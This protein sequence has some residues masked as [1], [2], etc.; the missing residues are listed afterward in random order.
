MKNAGIS[1]KRLFAG[2]G[3]AMF[4]LLHVAEAGTL[5][6]ATSPLGTSSGVNVKPNMLLILDDSGSMHNEYMP[7]FVGESRICPDVNQNGTFDLCDVG[8]PPYSSPDFN[9]IYYNPAIRYRPPKNANGTDW[10]NASTTTPL[11]EPFSASTST[12]DLGAFPDAAWCKNSSDTP[13]GDPATDANCAYYSVGVNEPFPKYPN[14][15]YRYRRAYNASVP[16][17]Y[18]MS[19]SPLWCT[20][21]TLTSC[22][23]KRDSSHPYPQY[24]ASAEVTG[25]A[26]S[27]SFYIAKAGA[28]TVN[29][30]CYNDNS[31]NTS[32]EGTNILT[33]PIAISGGD[34]AAN[35]DA[36]AD[37][38]VAKIGGG[39]VAT[40]IK[41]DTGAGSSKCSA[42]NL[43]R[44]PQV[45]VTAPGGA[46]STTNTAY[47]S[48][49]L[50]LEEPSSNVDFVYAIET[51]KGGV[52]YVP[53]SGQVTFRRVEI[54]SGSSYTKASGRTDCAG[55]SC[56]YEE[57]LQNFANWYSYYRRRLAMVKTS[58]SRAFSG[59][60]NTAPGV[61]F[62]VGLMAISSGS[63]QSD[64]CIAHNRDR[65]LQI[66]DFDSTQKS[67]FYTNLFGMNKCGWTPLR[68]ALARAGQVYAGVIT[69]YDPIQYSCQ[70]NFSFMATDGFWNT[71]WE[72]SSYGPYKE[73]K[74]TNVGNQDGG[75][76]SRPQLDALGKSDTLADVA[77]YYYKTDL[78]SQMADDVPTSSK[79]QLS[80]QHMVT[81]T[82]GLGV[83]GILGYNASY[84][85]GGSSDYNKI[86]QGTKDWPNPIDNEF[87]ERIDDLWHA[88][89][90]GR[91][92][93]FSAKNPDDVVFSLNEA[94]SAVAEITGSAAAAA[95]SNLEPVAGDNFAYV[96]SYVTR[97]WEGNLEAKSIDLTTGELSSTSTWSAQSLLDTAVGQSIPTG[98][99]GPGTRN[100]Y[101]FDASITG[102]DKK[103]Q[104][105]WANMQ[106]KAWDSYFDPTQLTQCSS[107]TCI[108]ATAQNLFNYLM[109]AADATPNHS[110]RARAHVLGDFVNSQ[111]VYVKAPTF[112]YTDAGYAA[113]KSG[114]TRGAMVYVGGND[115]F[116]H[117]FSADNGQ[118]QWAFVPSPLLP[119]L[120]QLGNS[121]FAHRYYVDGTISVGDIYVGGAWKTILV[122][123]LGGGGKYFIALDITDPTAPKA[124]WQFTDAR[125]GYS[126]GNPIITK[127][128]A[129]TTSAS[130]ADI[131]GKWV[132]LLTS[133]YNNGNTGVLY[134][135]DAYTGEEYY[136]IKTCTNQASAA[137]CASDDNGLAKINAW[138]NDPSHDNT[139]LYVY[140]GDLDGNLWRFDLHGKSAFKVAEVGE[141][142]TVKPE[143]ASV[144]NKR[145]IYFGTGIFL[146]SAD[147]A[148]RTTRTVFGIK[149]DP[150][151][152]APLTD[153]KTSG[154]LVEQTMATVGA[155]GRTITNPQTVDWNTASGWFV[156]LLEAGERVNVDP[157]LQLGS[158]VVASNV[159]DETGTSS[160]TVGGHS[161]LNVFDIL[162][163]AY[164]V[165]EQSNASNLV[166]T[167]V[168][169]ALTV[170][171][172][173]V[174]LP[175]GKLIA[176]AS[177]SDNRHP[178]KEP[179]VG[180][181]NL[182][183]K[184]VMWRELL[185]E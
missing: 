166:S 8:D 92:K 170:G 171:L 36:L 129:G 58:I 165:N 94:L 31:S 84:E 184:R 33:S 16:S 23:A 180:S 19:G 49:Y 87:E 104:M 66:A 116:L 151:A 178:P 3:A 128:P 169:N 175:N 131:G 109:G 60:S 97:V 181:A 53:A 147:R 38:L 156:N 115:G 125:M 137:T 112:G 113:Y 114:S 57:E 63:N 88:A 172:N 9:T 118:E 14:G 20:D 139:S 126:F 148:D 40:L 56:T 110:Y 25:V 79:D 133:G 54:R 182:P 29:F 12:Q 21:A 152:T 1:Q 107:G 108:D 93:Y 35:R 41:H 2:V 149:D 83:N 142:I 44:C 80:T 174:R 121:N 61:G 98:K 117:A 90:N 6:L 106:A 168:G 123:G 50:N 103:L 162:T 95:T 7:D 145:V 24:A 91:G 75:T 45:L 100:L 150:A 160:C 157:K 72:T 154:A 119:S 185:A 173:L 136:R 78:R 46:A 96:A 101:T 32:C 105:T 67:S 177:T 18:V 42:T 144:S 65:E 74:S 69:G 146:Q 76:T 70:Q 141:P 159:P 77:M 176:I 64:S 120:Y 153:V 127:L 22:A 143:M 167:R 39:F 82:M 111:P 89:V 163:G 124:L 55:A 26:A 135:V 27:R 11:K 130:N 10:A 15:T 4:S 134:V 179:A 158:L 102:A 34:S 62:R 5:T 164:V 68:G 17:Y 43:T 71:P 30:V 132:A 28:G 85:T 59:I 140:G 37:A 183:V 47:N 13:T 52:N 86:I 99:S 122:S 161:W 81:F 155:T 48:K 138:A 51:L 73:D